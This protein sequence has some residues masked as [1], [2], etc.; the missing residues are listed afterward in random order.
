MDW[1]WFFSSL[2]QSSAAIVGIFGAF[3]ITKVLSNQVMFGEKAARFKSL[4]TAASRLAESADNLA[5]E[6]YTR[7]TTQKQLE[8]AEELLE[9]DQALEAEALYSRLRFPPFLARDKAVDALKALK[10][11][12]EREADAERRRLEEAARQ[13]AERRRKLGTLGGMS[14]F[15]PAG[16]AFAMPVS[17]S[18]S[19]P[20]SAFHPY[21]E[22]QKE[23]EAINAL[24]VE[25]RHHMR[26]ISDFLETVSSNPESSRAIT[27]ALIL[28]A[29]LFLAGVI[30]PLSFMP[31]PSSWTPALELRGFWDRALSLRGVL[32]TAVSLIFM[33]ALMM[34][35][36]MNS[37]MQYSPKQ[38]LSLR[39][40]TS[41]EAYSNYY[42]I[43]ERNEQAAREKPRTE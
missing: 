3:I 39:A 17:Q 19:R 43:A 26:T 12:R 29:A 16:D 4:Q 33:A 32:L 10:E 31:T 2:S 24:E 38:I 25:V 13:Q 6:W 1:N 41:I 18:Y 27:W 23:L 35:A 11:R 28:V 40:F 22:L 42:A 5:F 20:I 7:L 9:K 8:E 37:R 36:V 34:F 14:G 21:A 30:Y 15:G